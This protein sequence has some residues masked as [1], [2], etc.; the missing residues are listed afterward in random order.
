[1]IKELKGEN[2][3]D[4]GSKKPEKEEKKADKGTNE[5]NK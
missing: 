1:L 4:Y 3:N 5:A 2:K